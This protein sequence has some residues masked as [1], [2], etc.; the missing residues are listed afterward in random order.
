MIARGGFG[1]PSIYVS[2]P[3]VP[4]FDTQFHWGNDR[5]ELVE[6]AIRRAQGRPWRFHDT[7]GVLPAAP[8]PVNR[9]GGGWAVLSS[10]GEGERGA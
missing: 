6:A 5:I 2:R 1:S 4:G 8:A 7:C 9:P 3:D 10:T